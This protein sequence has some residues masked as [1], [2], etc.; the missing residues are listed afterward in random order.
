M[1]SG[2][3]PIW[4]EAVRDV[5]V[6][7][8]SQANCFGI[9]SALVDFEP[10]PAFTFVRQLDS[11]SADDEQAKLVDLCAEHFEDGVRAELLEVGGGTLPPVRVVLRW[12]LTHEVDSTRRRNREA[13]RLAVA[14]AI[15]RAAT[16]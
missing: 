3:Q 14:E 7:C 12:I 4:T 9:A 2:R 15:R 11:G 10:Q 8:G 5:R 13:G 6:R 16:R 1:T